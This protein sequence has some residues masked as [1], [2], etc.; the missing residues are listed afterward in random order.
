MK[1][2]RGSILTNDLRA[3]VRKG[4]IGQSKERNAC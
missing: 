2:R 3:K 4:R 1:A